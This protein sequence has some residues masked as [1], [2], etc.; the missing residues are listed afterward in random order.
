MAPTATIETVTIVRPLKVIAVMC[1]FIAAL[2]L[3]L[4]IAATTWIVSDTERRGLWEMCIVHSV[5]DV[6]CTKNDSYSTNIV[7]G[8]LCILSMIICLGST[9][10]AT[11]GLQTKNC[12]FKYL[13]YKVAM[14]VMFSALFVEC[15]ALI[16]FPT[17]YLKELTEV[18]E[19]P[20]LMWEYG[21]AYGVGWGAAIFMFGACVLLYLDKE[22]EEITYHEKTCYNEDDYIEEAT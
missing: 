17:K 15:I 2:L 11:L 1:G 12:R 6:E 4:S 9:L 18:S 14:A 20:D 16:L 10:A 3:M 19:D 21:W 7:C 13:M 22:S 5:D 8:A